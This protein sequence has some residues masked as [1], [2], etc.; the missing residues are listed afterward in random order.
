M[1]T[2]KPIMLGSVSKMMLLKR[3]GP[4]LLLQHLEILRYTWMLTMLL[5]VLLIIYYH[6]VMV[7]LVFPLVNGKLQTL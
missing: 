1:V 7:E 4:S 6:L 2:Q 5:L 3:Q